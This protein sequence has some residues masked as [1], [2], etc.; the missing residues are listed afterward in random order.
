MSLSWEKVESLPFVIRNY[1]VSTDGDYFDLIVRTA[2][3]YGD[4][5]IT[6]PLPGNARRYFIW[7]DNNLIRYELRLFREGDISYIKSQRY[8]YLVYDNGGH[9]NFIFFDTVKKIIEIYEPISAMWKTEDYRAR[10]KIAKHVRKRFAGFVVS[11]ESR[12]CP[13]IPGPQH[14]QIY[15]EYTNSQVWLST[16][17]YT[18]F[19]VSGEWKDNMCMFW[20][21]LMLTLKF[22]NP[23]RSFQEMAS[24]FMSSTQNLSQ[25]ILEFADVITRTCLCVMRNTPEKYSKPDPTHNWSKEEITNCFQTGFKKII[26]EILVEFEEQSLCVVQNSICVNCRTKEGKWVMENTEKS[27]PFCSH[28]CASYFWNKK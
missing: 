24:Y 23:S 3:Y 21:A 18:G 17:I 7:Y 11:S 12:V 27:G 20:S 25:I 10:K 2:M 14:K 9:A 16:N 5:S 15:D 19:T 6:H 13:N 4:I 26:E 8:S 28:E 1:V 22:R